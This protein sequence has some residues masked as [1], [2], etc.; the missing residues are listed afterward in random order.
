MRKKWFREW[1][2][3]VR[4]GDLDVRF[5]RL[6]SDVRDVMSD[7][8]RPDW[9]PT[10]EFR[11]ELDDGDGEVVLFGNGKDWANGLWFQAVK[12]GASLSSLKVFAG[13]EAL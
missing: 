12:K 10:E 1:Q 2:A 13:D 8:P 9:M 4:R 7:D 5:Y 11:V 6:Y 3:D